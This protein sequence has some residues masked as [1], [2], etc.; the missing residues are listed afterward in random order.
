VPPALDH[1]VMQALERDPKG[2]SGK[3]AREALALLPA[4]LV[5]KEAPA[6]QK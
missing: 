4:P 5:I 1:L 6:P 3:S 2:A